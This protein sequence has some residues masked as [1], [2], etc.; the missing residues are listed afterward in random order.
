MNCPHCQKPINPAAMLGAKG[1]LTKGD[2]KRRDPAKMRAAS[3][4]RWEIARAKEAQPAIGK[5]NGSPYFQELMKKMD[6]AIKR[7]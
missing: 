6:K 3:L 2:S 5:P 4:K 1:G 7:L